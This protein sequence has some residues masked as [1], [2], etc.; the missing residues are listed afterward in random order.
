MLEGQIHGAVQIT[1]ASADKD[2]ARHQHGAWP[3]IPFHIVQHDAQPQSIGKL[4]EREGPSP[5]LLHADD[6]EFRLIRGLDHYQPRVGGRVPVAA[7]HLE[8]RPEWQSLT[9]VIPVSANAVYDEPTEVRS[10]VEIQSADAS[11]AWNC[12]RA[13]IQKSLL[14]AEGAGVG[15]RHKFHPSF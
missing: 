5:L 9:G 12:R 10:E 13:G 8:P 11:D 3:N 1:A 15:V 2:R 7:S 14:T 4:L 6:Q